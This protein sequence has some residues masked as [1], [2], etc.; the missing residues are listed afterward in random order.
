M[1]QHA[2]TAI[3]LTVIMG[4]ASAVLMLPKP[5][6][7]VSATMMTPNSR[8][9]ART[10]FCAAPFCVRTAC[11]A[12]QRRQEPFPLGGGAR[13]GVYAQQQQRTFFSN[14]AS[15]FNQYANRRDVDRTGPR[16]TP[17][18]YVNDK[19]ADASKD[20]FSSTTKTTTVNNAT[21]RTEVPLSPAAA[22]Q[23]LPSS[24]LRWSCDPD[25]FDFETTS[26]LEELRK[27]TLLN[28][29]RA[30]S[31]LEFGIKMNQTGYNLY[32]LG[33]TGSGKRTMV[34]NY[35]EDQSLSE[36]PA[37]DWAYVH[38][39]DEPDHPKAIKLP[40]GLGSHLKDDLAHLIEDIQSAVPAALESDKLRN[41]IAEAKESVYEEQ[42]KALEKFGE[43]AKEHDLALVRT[44]AGI[45]LGG[46]ASDPSATDENGPS[47]PVSEEK[48][49]QLRASIE[50]LTP[51]LQEIIGKYPQL[52]RKA[53]QR[54]KELQQAAAKAAIGFLFDPVKERYSN[55]PD[56]LAHLG[57]IEANVVERAEDIHGKDDEDEAESFM[58]FITKPRNRPVPFERYNINL[59]VDSNETLET[60]APVV[61]EE[62]PTVY[63]LI[64]RTEHINQ[65]GA[66]FTDFSLIK[67]GAL[68]RA[69]GGYLVLNARDVLTQ[70]FA[71]EALKRCLRSGAIKIESLG[72]E[73]GLISTVS[74]QPEPIELNAKIVLLGDRLLY[75]LLCQYDPEFND[76][77]KV[78]VDFDDEMDRS[79]EASI[80]YARMLA[81]LAKGK[82]LKPMDKYAVSAVIEQAARLVGDQEKLSTHMRSCVDLLCE[83]DYWA[84]VDNAKIIG[85]KHVEKAIE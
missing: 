45:M 16:V 19:L 4:F 1:V 12:L 82:D 78:A 54:V 62:N 17:L 77:F 48:K 58:S 50:L 74:L 30:T 39:F 51:E 46:P 59:I 34:R 83:S 25:Q 63:N 38:N 40:A 80:V 11:T 55:L 85:R 53:D 49:K 84:G 29:A 52:K 3:I 75:Y 31:A 20:M 44:P 5:H 28:Q 22:R 43:K 35:L 76:L 23:P 47:K 41:D 14:R 13:A 66:F 24:K 79:P 67:A 27:G 18:F 7:L 8:L 72:A 70:P 73:Y 26:E 21:T 57:A 64:G 15:S 36:S 9:I 69:N 33:P 65:F 6:F 10:A 68:H 60:G 71:W 42:Q 37:S 2:T 32:V 81:T 56:V 61:Y